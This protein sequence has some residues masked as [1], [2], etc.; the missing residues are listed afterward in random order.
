M[1]FNATCG[2][3]DRFDSSEHTRVMGVAEERRV[4]GWAFGS[5]FGG[6]EKDS[7]RSA[8]PTALVAS[9]ACASS[10]AQWL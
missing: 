3:A 4:A 10:G 7:T 2:S 1:H 8:S 9:L 5:A 6:D